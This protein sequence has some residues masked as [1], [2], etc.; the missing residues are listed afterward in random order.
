MTTTTEATA[1]WHSTNVLLLCSIRLV[2]LLDKLQVG[3]PC[4]GQRTVGRRSTVALWGR[5]ESVGRDTWNLSASVELCHL[6]TTHI[7]L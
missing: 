6:P 4:P 5:D 7:H 2:D 3:L 1:P